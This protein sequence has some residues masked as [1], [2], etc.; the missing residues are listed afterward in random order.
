MKKLVL[1]LWL[2]TSSVLSFE[3]SPRDKEIVEKS[4]HYALI[5]KL[6][7]QGVI[8][9]PLRVYVE[10]DETTYRLWQNK[11][12]LGYSEIS[13]P[14]CQLILGS[15]VRP[16]KSNRNEIVIDQDGNAI[17]VNLRSDKN[18][19]F[20]LLRSIGSIKVLMIKLSGQRPGYEKIDL[21]FL[22]NLVHLEL[23]S[24]STQVMILPVSNNLEVIK[25]VTF[26]ANSIDNIDNKDKLVYFEMYGELNGLEK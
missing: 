25:S 4:E 8:D 11:S 10:S 9:S 21:S 6:Y 15:K 14:N 19:D 20:N 16:C 13:N 26:K 24:M 2:V 5:S 17:I 1:L 7:N 23:N 3:L 12:R 22:S 18:F